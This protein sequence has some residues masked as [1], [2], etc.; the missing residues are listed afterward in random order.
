M[1]LNLGATDPI[2]GF[3]QIV[4]LQMSTLITQKTENVTF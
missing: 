1:A 4:L 3:Q 2:Q